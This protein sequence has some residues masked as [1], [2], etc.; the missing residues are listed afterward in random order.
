MLSDDL[1]QMKN[2][3]FECYLDEVIQ[4]MGEDEFAEKYAQEEMLDI[5]YEKEVFI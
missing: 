3:Y 1:Q 5:N 4:E 2:K